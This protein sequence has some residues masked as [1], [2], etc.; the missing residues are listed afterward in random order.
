MDVPRYF[1]RRSRSGIIL[2]LIFTWIFVVFGCVSASSGNDDDISIPEVCTILLTPDGGDHAYAY[3]V[4]NGE[5]MIDVDEIVPPSSTASYEYDSYR[6]QSSFRGRIM[7]NHIE[8]SDH[9]FYTQ[10]GRGPVGKS[11]PMCTTVHSFDLRYS[12]TAIL[13]SDGTYQWYGTPTGGQITVQWMDDCA[14]GGVEAKTKVSPQSDESMKNTGTWSISDST[15]YPPVDQSIYTPPLDSPE[16]TSP[17]DTSPIEQVIQSVQYPGLSVEE[18]IQRYETWKEI[19]AT[20]RDEYSNELQTIREEIDTISVPD[21][22]VQLKNLDSSIRKDEDELAG[23]E[24]KY[25][26]AIQSVTAGVPSDKP[27]GA[28]IFGDQSLSSY[29]SNTFDAGSIMDTASGYREVKEIYDSL[30]QNLEYWIDY[31]TQK[32]NEVNEKIERKKELQKRYDDLQ[33]NV[34]TI[35]LLILDIDYELNNIQTT[36]AGPS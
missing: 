21:L 28:E 2:F 4:N 22:Q 26:E 16:V 9:I 30:R 18:Q 29:T 32:K 13:S 11:G 19:A 15:G 5:V 25:D 7:G 17:P 1:R 24:E 14:A 10:K 35:D 3:Q 34:N 23:L 33:K 8:G 12:A 36:T 27:P 31:H 6:F 20:K